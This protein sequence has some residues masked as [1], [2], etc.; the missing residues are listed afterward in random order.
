ML[1]GGGA[2][3]VVLAVVVLSIAAV[4]PCV[5]GPRLFDRIYTK[6]EGNTDKNSCTRLLSVDKVIG[7]SSPQ[8]GGVGA[9]FHISTQ[10]E[11]D[12]FERASHHSYITVISQNMFSKSD[13]LKELL[14]YSKFKGALV[15][16]PA[17]ETLDAWSPDDENPN[18]D[19]G[20]ETPAK[21]WN[22]AGGGFG[23]D[24]AKGSHWQD[25]SDRPIFF[26]T[27]DDRDLILTSMA[28]NNNQLTVVN[29]GYPLL[30]AELTNFMWAAGDAKTC[31]RR[32]YCD[33]L[34]SH[35]VW[36][37]MMEYNTS[38]EVI[39]VTAQMDSLAFFHD[40]ALGANAD[41]SGM[42][43]LLGAAQLLGD[44]DNAAIRNAARNIMFMLFNGEAFGYIGSSK[45]AYQMARNPSL[46]PSSSLPMKFHQV[47]YLVE[48]G[49]LL[50]GTEELHAYS[51]SKSAA[52]DDVVAEFQ[53][54]AADLNT[55]ISLSYQDGS[56]IPPASLRMIVHEIDNT[57]Q[58]EAFGGVFITD[59]PASG[60]TNSY[61]HS[62]LD[63]A[64]F[65]DASSNITVEKL[66]NIS[67]VVARSLWS[68]AFN[69]NRPMPN[70]NA[71]CDYIRELLY[72]I[73]VDQQCQL[74]KDSVVTL[75]AEQGPISRYVG[76]KPTAGSLSRPVGFFFNQLAAA[77]AVD[78]NVTTNSTDGCTAN[79]RPPS[80]QRIRWRGTDVC[81]LSATF[82]HLAW[83]PA[84]NGYYS[85]KDLGTPSF[86]YRDGRDP[87][88]STWVESTW[89]PIKARMFLIESPESQLATVLGGFA[90][91]LVSFG[92][93]Y[94]VQKHMT[95]ES[96]SLLDP[97]GE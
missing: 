51:Y 97:D 75:G 56:D 25:Y 5:A 55:D 93:V 31:L 27:P 48:L 20:L 38:Q 24:G 53:D 45:M 30:A 15:Y 61:Y 69:D 10:D 40:Q 42:I 52:V 7:C 64:D 29:P 87:R 8:K 81:Y 58:R 86:N 76:V 28:E 95:Y 33:P 62:R 77:I 90:W 12:S 74:V 94:F 91:F 79:G 37:T 60:Y 41:A 26:L 85:I 1:C 50:S 67:S 35:N 23:G 68:L 54:A 2:S 44:P 82:T 70:V 92:L 19:Y 71:N 47:P 59:H 3:A 83:S 36:G 49:Q 9:L 18:A 16:T 46:F 17:N 43:A 13:A 32:E 57:T 89:D 72:C 11:L 14:T 65:I 73:T 4:Q 84:F 21:R 96:H 78:R 22:G 88:W 34:R 6:L 63:N 39:M 66:C 80:F